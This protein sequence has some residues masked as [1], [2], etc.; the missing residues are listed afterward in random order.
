MVG[1]LVGQRCLGR[2][3]PQLRAPT[4]RRSSQ[5]ADRQRPDSESHP[6]GRRLGAWGRR[7]P[8]RAPPCGL[9]LC[10]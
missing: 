4:G 1:G 10:L 6:A 9:G 3:A 8:V 2:H 7:C 5:P